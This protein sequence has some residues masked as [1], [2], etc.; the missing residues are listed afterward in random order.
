V[1]A[2]ST[3]LAIGL[4]ARTLAGLRP[5]RLERFTKGVHNE[6]PASGFA[7]P[8]SPDNTALLLTAP[9]DGSVFF[10]IPRKARSLV[11]TTDTYWEGDPDEV[12][13]DEGDI[14]YLS[15]GCTECLLPR[16]GIYSRGRLQDVVRPA[17]PG[18]G[19]GRAIFTVP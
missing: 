3:V 14:D 10:A 7:A 19:D 11:G 8:F 12:R 16:V 4:W 1:R 2:R 18:E 5:E 9:Q 13:A 17:Y 15:F 6:V